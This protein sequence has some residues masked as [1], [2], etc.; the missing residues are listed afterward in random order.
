MIQILHPGPPHFMNVDLK[1]SL[2]SPFSL[3][4]TLKLT[5]EIKRTELRNKQTGMCAISTANYLK[6]H[7]EIKC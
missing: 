5:Q 4:L 6:V 7:V 3:N 1:Q 2:I